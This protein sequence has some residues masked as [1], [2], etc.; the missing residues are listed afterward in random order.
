ML[1]VAVA[2]CA[3][4]TTVR[5]EQ[6][7]EFVAP[8][9]ARVSVFGV[10]H[11][12]RMSDTAWAALESKIAPA[13]GRHGCE[14]GYGPRMREA[15]PELASSVAHDISENGVDDALLTRVASGATGD[16]ILLLMSYRQLPSSHDGG[17]R[18]VQRPV[19][20]AGGRMTRGS[21][22]GSGSRPVVEEERLFELSASLFSVELH[23]LVAQV[24]LRHL[25]DDLDEAMDA[26]AKKLTLLLP[27]ATCVGWNWETD[28]GV[29]D[30]E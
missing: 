16:Y 1:A 19:P 11:D 9:A 24:D 5:V 3:S 8:R 30:V 6:A 22:L 26:F 25:G 4:A 12:G 17:A 13:L 15:N 27:N 2:A 7:P 14:V 18:P 21:G 29:G 20:M 28:S 23:K 10:F